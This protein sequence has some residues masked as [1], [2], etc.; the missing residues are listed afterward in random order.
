MKIL[1]L[2]LL[3]GLSLFGSVGKI[4]AL[5]GKV[6]I[7]RQN[8]LLEGI[9]G[10]DLEEKDLVM[11]DDKSKAQLTLNDGT[12]LSL[13]KN[14]KLDINEYVFDEKDSS[15][16]KANFKFAEGTFKSITGAIGK[17]SPEKFKLETKSASIGIRGTIVV[18]SQEK[19]AC[20]QG[21]IT[22]TSAGVTQVLGAGMMTNTEQ[23]KPPTQPKKIEGNLLKEVDATTTEDKGSN[24]NENK[25]QESNNN[26]E[27]TTENRDN[28]QNSLSSDKVEK[29]AESNPVSTISTISEVAKTATDNTTSTQKLQ[30]DATVSLYE[31]K[32]N[33]V[34]QAATKLVS[35]SN[36]ILSSITSSLTKANTAAQT[37]LQTV[38]NAST[39]AVEDAQIASNSAE[40]AVTAANGYS[41]QSQIL[42]IEISSL[43]EKMKTVS[44]NEAVILYEQ[45]QAK[46]NSLNTISS[47]ITDLSNIAFNSSKAV[48]NIPFYSK[49]I[50]I[51]SEIET[52]GSVSFTVDSS[53]TNVTIATYTTSYGMDPVLILLKKNSNDEYIVVDNGKND[54][55]WVKSPSWYNAILNLELDVGDYMI[56]VADFPFNSTEAIEGENKG[57]KDNGKINLYIS[58]L[59]DLTFDTTAVDKYSYIRKLDNQAYI[60]NSSYTLAKIEENNPYLAA[61]ADSDVGTTIKINDYG[62]FV[63]ISDSFNYEG[64]VFLNTEKIDDGSSWGYWITSSSNLSSINDMK[65]VWVSGNKV[66][67]STNYSANFR[68]QVIGS[69]TNGSNTGYIKLDSNNLFQATIDIGSASITKS[70]IKFNDSLNGSWSGSFDTTGSNVNTSGFSANIIK[71][72]D[73]LS[74]NTTPN[75]MGSIAGTYYGVKNEVKS[76]GGSFNMSQETSTETLTANGVFKA[77]LTGRNE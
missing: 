41:I 40:Q 15:N 46:V 21:E 34:L 10:F 76:I 77:G 69:V 68:G 18:G 51:G 8:Q 13:G 42:S 11:T 17:V 37:A 50:T 30:N 36:L 22:V 35:E 9:L 65:S 52:V 14:S 59:V 64:N 29:I 71:N 44:T 38:S 7:D 54:D 48:V 28:E 1:I 33:E 55:S 49:S 19:V 53:N 57:K 67:P 45:I 56:R 75:T 20:T 47:Q 16:S 39:F 58:S 43:L 31:Q 62:Y 26:N 23:G 27:S 72:T 24:S 73:S 2:I 4:S 60:N 5:N 61:L 25:V 63:T 66:T 6:I 74:S 70:M 3:Y 12:V 32:K